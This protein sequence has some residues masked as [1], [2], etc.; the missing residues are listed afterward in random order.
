MIRVSAD[1][2]IMINLNEHI[3][4]CPGE[5]STET[6]TIDVCVGPNDN[7]VVSIK[8]SGMKLGNLN[9]TVEAK[10]TNGIRDC[11]SIEEGEGLTDILV[12]PLRVKPEGFPVEKVKQML[13]MNF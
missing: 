10:I 4:L 6:E 12:R 13:T 2:V 11:K 5:V 3:I 7:E 8:S 9:I 1:S